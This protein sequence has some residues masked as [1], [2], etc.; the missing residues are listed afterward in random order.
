MRGSRARGGKGAVCARGGVRIRGAMAPRAVTLHRVH[1][2]IAQTIRRADLRAPHAQHQGGRCRDERVVAERCAVGVARRSAAP[3]SIPSPG[4]TNERSGDHCF[5]KCTRGYSRRVASCTAG[6][7]HW[8]AVQAAT[9]QAAASSRA[10][11]AEGRTSA[12]ERSLCGA[13]PAETSTMG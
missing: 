12:R 2:D 6:W 10:Q 7:C 11:L 9:R 5:K 1:V 13:G 3:G 8:A 4:E